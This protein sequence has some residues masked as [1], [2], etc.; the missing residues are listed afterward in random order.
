MIPK[1]R[2]TMNIL[3]RTDDAMGR[4]G[5]FCLTVPKIFM[6]RHSSAIHHIHVARENILLWGMSYRFDAII[7]INHHIHYHSKKLKKGQNST[8]I[9]I[10]L[11][12]CLLHEICSANKGY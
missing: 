12:L 9:L 3:S 2:S 8:A 10:F 11:K 5:L 6:G 1:K 7:F 4:F